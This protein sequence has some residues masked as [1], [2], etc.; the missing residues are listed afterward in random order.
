VT[1]TSTNNTPDAIHIRQNDKTTPEACVDLPNTP[2]NDHTS[3]ATSI[4]STPPRPASLRVTL[5]LAAWVDRLIAF[6]DVGGIE[7]AEV[8]TSAR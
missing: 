1:A 3:G 6:P 2:P 4:A 8:V 7:V 5:R